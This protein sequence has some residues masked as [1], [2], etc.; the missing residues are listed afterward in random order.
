MF[1]TVELVFEDQ[2]DE[3]SIIWSDF[4][5]L[6]FQTSDHNQFPIIHISKTVIK[7]KRC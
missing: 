3:M 2:S 4:I 1:D 5:R 7:S 6:L